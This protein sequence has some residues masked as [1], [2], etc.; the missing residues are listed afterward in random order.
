MS[1]ARQ[2][3]SVSGI[4]S[5]SRRVSGTVSQ[6]NSI[7]E[8]R[9]KPLS[10]F[11]PQ[12]ELDILY[13]DTTNEDIY[14]WDG[15]SYVKLCNADASQIIDDLNISA[16]K[17]WSSLKINETFVKQSD[18][19]DLTKQVF[20]GTT[21][22]WNSHPDIISKKDAIYVYTDWSTVNGVS[23]AGTKIGDGNTYVVDLPFTPSVN[24]TQEEKDYW[25]D[26]VAAKISAVESDNLMLY[27]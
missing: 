6:G 9:F 25:N 13:V 17:T 14:Y 20:S 24:V 23:V 11:P 12:G 27:K 16:T 8:L 10:E 19:E 4:V 26:K 5:V 1:D 18:I 21:E 22:Y 3:A 2:E 7:K 15:N